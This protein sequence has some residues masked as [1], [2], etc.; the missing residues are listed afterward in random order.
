MLARY[1]Q[2]K[3][4]EKGFTLYNKNFRNLAD[5]FKYIDKDQTGFLTKKDFRTVLKM[6]GVVRAP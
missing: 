6:C 2:V 4:N 5:K 1:V 3:L